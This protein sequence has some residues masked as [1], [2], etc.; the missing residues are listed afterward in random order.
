MQD[1]PPPKD[2]R[3]KDPLEWL[4]LSDAPNWK[5]ARPLGALFGMLLILLFTLALVAA[6][7]TL[8]K[9]FVTTS[10]T[11]A[12]GLGTGALIVALLGAPFLIWNTVIKH[13]ALG[14]QKEGHLTDR[15]SKAV[16]QLGVEKTVKLADKDGIAIETTRPNIEVRIG[17]ILLLERI[18]QD[19]TA[20]DK[21][22][23]HVRVMEILCAYLRENAPAREAV[24]F[25]LGDWEPLKEDP[26]D[27][28]RV[29]HEAYRLVR[30]KDEFERKSNVRDWAQSLAATRADI[31]LA[32]RVIGR[33]DD[34]QRKVEATWPDPPTTTTKWVFDLP[35]PPPA[36]PRWHQSPA[37]ACGRAQSLH[38]ETGRMENPDRQLWRLSPRSARHQPATR[39]SFRPEPFRCP[40]APG[41]DGGGRPPPG[42]D[43]GG[44]PHR[45]A[46]AGGRPQRGA[47]AGGR[48]PRGADAGGRPHRGADGGGRPQR[49]ADAGGKP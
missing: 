6:L 13:K 29:T 28:E 18:A 49:G 34:D 37:P 10:E 36:R 8:L 46:D 14:F 27:E 19:S 32:L 16:E 35:C 33:R 24:D 3:P 12:G 23:D 39:R 43:G 2:T 7:V 30:F 41:A 31:A 1:S 20:Y 47:D 4:G 48:P 21:G 40:A 5:V 38:A 22:R 25:S 45:G 42:A 44:R 26:T 9:V 17:A 11:P 15:L